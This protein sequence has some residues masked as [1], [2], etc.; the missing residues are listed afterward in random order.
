MSVMPLDSQPP[1]ETERVQALMAEL[2]GEL[3]RQHK[4]LH[5]ANLSNLAKTMARVAPDAEPRNEMDRLVGPFYSTASLEEWL[6]ISRQALDQRVRARKLLGCMATDRVRLYPSWQFTDRGLVI[7]G[8]D[9]V[10]PVLAAGVDAPWTW[11]L[12]LVSAIPDELEGLSPAEW[13]AKGRD[14][15]PVITLARQDAAIWAV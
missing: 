10:L 7:P 2:Q 14:P 12:W 1:E 11:A 15:V 5:G 3:H 6:G 9:R 4:T 8:L 13:L